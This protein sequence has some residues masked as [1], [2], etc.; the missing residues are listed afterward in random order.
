MISWFSQDFPTFPHPPGPLCSSLRRRNFDGSSSEG[1]WNRHGR[2]A[3]NLDSMFN[4][5]IVM[6]MSTKCVHATMGNGRF[7]LILLQD[8]LI[9]YN[10]I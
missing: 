6:K 4:A 2:R 9:S 3:G 8:H 7:W 10:I 5:E 1:G